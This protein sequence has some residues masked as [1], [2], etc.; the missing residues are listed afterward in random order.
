MG[1]DIVG[2][3]LPTAVV[4]RRQQQHELDLALEL[5]EIS[6]SLERLNGHVFPLMF[7]LP[8]HAKAAFV[9]SVAKVVQTLRNPKEYL[10]RAAARNVC[11]VQLE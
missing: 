3:V 2:R 9:V 5:G 8:H 1:E 6:P 10:C 7:A 4:M 11:C